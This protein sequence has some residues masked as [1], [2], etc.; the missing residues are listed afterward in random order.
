MKKILLAFIISQ[1]F[2]LSAISLSLGVD[3]MSFDSFYFKNLS[4]KGAASLRVNDS[5]RLVLTASYHKSKDIDNQL[6]AFDIG[7]SAAYN[8]PSCY[9]L[10][11]K[12]TLLNPV[13]LTGYD[14]PTSEPLFLTSLAVGYE[15]TF[16]FFSLDLSLGLL[17]AFKASEGAYQIL[18]SALKQ[19]SEYRFSVLT[20]VRFDFRK[21]E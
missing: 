17:D 10:Y 9:G 14:A 6:Q 8:I 16:P 19:Y 4:L 11:I 18:R 12:A 15:F 2:T 7:L 13:F 20:S 5:I 1:L 3:L 21:K